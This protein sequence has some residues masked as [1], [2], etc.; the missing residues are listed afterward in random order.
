VYG[1]EALKAGS[2]GTPVPG[3]AYQVVTPE[4]EIAPVGG[5]GL[6][7]MLHPFPGLART[8]WDDHERYVKTYF[9]RYPGKYFTADEAVVDS[10]GQLWVLGR[11]DDV[12]NVAAHRLSTMEIESVVA[13][14]TGVADAAV[15]GA[16][17]KIKGTVPIAF[18][19]LKAGNDAADVVPRVTRAVNDA[20]GGIA[21][22]DRVYICTALPKTRAGKTV[23]RILREIAESG[24]AKGDTTGVEDVEVVTGLIKEVNAQKTSAKV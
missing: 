1:V 9:T 22:L 15:V 21:R 19:V 18:V 23:R 8:V 6:L 24:E 14:Q 10:D 20:I 4:G 12:I 3:H 16:D 5:K 11:G 17:D 13:A 2:C 7:V